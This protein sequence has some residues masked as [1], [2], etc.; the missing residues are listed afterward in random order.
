MGSIARRR[1]AALA[2]A[3]FIG[4]AGTAYA[5]QDVVITTSGD[6]L[7]G[8]IIKVE[9]DIL[10][11]STPY[12]DVDFKIEWDQIA[13]I[14]SKRQFLVETFDGRRLT[15]SLT[16][17]PS[18]KPVVVVAGTSVSLADVSM[19]QPFERTFLSRFDTA[20]DFGYSMT[21]ANSAKQLSLSTNLS[22]RD[23]RYVDVAFASIFRNSQANAP[24]TQRWEVGNDFRRLL[25]ARW[26]V[27]TTQEFLNSE[28]QGLDLRTTIGGGGGRYLTRTA[29]QYLAVGGGIAWTNENYTDQALAAK[30]SAEA[31][32]GTEFMTEKLKITDLVTRFTYYP[33]LTIDDRYRLT[34]R[35]DLDFNLPGDWYFKVAVFDN[36]DSQPPAGF[37]KNDYGWSNG[38]GFKF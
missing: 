19:V 9:K 10:T 23:E 1:I 28:E 29:S 3:M 13:A 22:Y 16:L 35:L 2:L 18:K 14:E 7:V 33:S 36:F 25:G 34:Y 4:G 31:Y 20:L 27:N 6:R 11:F 26:Y 12:S 15:G 30:D 21:K 32:L 38:F 17:D 37:S 5:Q 24:E 8:E